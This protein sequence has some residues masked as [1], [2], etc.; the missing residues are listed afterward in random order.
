MKQQMLTYKKYNGSIEIDLESGCL[1]G[2]ILF[3]K[4]LVTYEADSVGQLKVEFQAAVDDYLETCEQLGRE[5]QKAYSGTFNVRFGPD[6]HK[7]VAVCAYLS[8]TTL[9]DFIKTAAKEKITTDTKVHKHV[10]EHVIKAVVVDQSTS[11]VPVQYGT[12]SPW[13]VVQQTNMQQ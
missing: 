2:K 1:H 13:E 5:P 11:S 8:G 3:I 12:P 9:N 10:H 7:E 4:D 6:L